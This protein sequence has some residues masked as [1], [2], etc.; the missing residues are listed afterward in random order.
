MRHQRKHGS[1]QPRPIQASLVFR[2]LGSRGLGFRGWGLGVLGLGLL[3][4]QWVAMN[5]LGR[6]II[7]FVACSACCHV[8]SLP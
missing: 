5:K 2:G 6:K 7:E 4:S 1:T 3:G 8:P